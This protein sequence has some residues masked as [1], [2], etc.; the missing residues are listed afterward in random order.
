MQVFAD[1]LVG[2][3]MGI[4]VRFIAARAAPPKPHLGDQAGGAGSLGASAP[5]TGDTTAP[6]AVECQSFLDNVIAQFV[7][8][9]EHGMIKADRAPDY[10]L[11]VGGSNPSG[12]ASEFN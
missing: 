1:F 7:G 5:G 9:L 3:G 10:N 4:S 2:F 8:V 6:L 11:G 12:R